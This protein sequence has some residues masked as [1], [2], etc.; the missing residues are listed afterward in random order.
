VS[1]PESTDRLTHFDEDG[2]PA[3]V[4]ISHKPASER[5][6]TAR[7]AVRMAA[8]TLEQALIAGANKKGDVRAVAELAGIMG[9]KRT[10]DLIPLCHPLP[11]SSVKVTVTPDDTLP[12]LVVE[13]VAK[14]TGATGVEMEALTAVSAA[15]LTVYDM[16]KAVDRGMEIGPIALQE[17]RGGTSGTW[18]RT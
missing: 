10:S 3:M 11:L 13:A 16:L 17:K 2:R 7:G 6:A 4:D 12:G 8:P 15:C 5:S 9:A 18:V 1:A 14:T